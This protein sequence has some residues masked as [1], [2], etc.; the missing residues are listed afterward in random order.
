MKAGIA[1]MMGGAVSLYKDGW[2]DAGRLTLAFVADEEV[3]GLGTQVFLRQFHPDGPTGVVI[4]EPTENQIHIAHR[5]VIR[6]RITVHG[7]GCHS[8]QPQD[9]INAILA[10]TR[11]VQALEP[12]HLQRQ[13]IP[14]PILPS[15]TMCCTMIQG[16]EKDNMIPGLCSCVLDCRTIPGDTSQALQQQVEEYIAAIADLPAGISIQVEPF[17]EVKPGMTQPDSPLVT[18]AK[19]ACQ[20][21]LGQLPLVRDFPACCDMSFYTAA[22]LDTIICGPGSI[23]Q[24]HTVDEFVSIRQLQDS[25]RLYEALAKLFKSAPVF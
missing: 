20:D 11:I 22:D 4:G 24:A 15:P 5:G 17:I 14:H 19:Q 9:G 2:G 6:L 13:A 18:L 25:V 23:S 7:K 3:D 1:A 12:L 16:G 10:M 21:V 8:S